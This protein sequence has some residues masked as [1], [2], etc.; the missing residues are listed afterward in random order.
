[1]PAHC[2]YRKIQKNHGALIAR[3]PHSGRFHIY[4]ILLLSFCVSYFYYNFSWRFPMDKRKTKNEKRK[5]Q[6]DGRDGGKVF[7]KFFDNKLVSL[8]CIY[9]FRFLHFPRARFRSSLSRL[10]FL[11]FIGISHNSILVMMLTHVSVYISCLIHNF[12]SSHLHILR[13]FFR[14]R[15][16]RVSL[17]GVQMTRYTNLFIKSKSID[18]FNY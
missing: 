9:P 3:A 18:L 8:I 15:M 14:R 5:R 17:I 12:F 11:S 7:L 4:P 13:R 10:S 1:M 6:W 2:A 16:R